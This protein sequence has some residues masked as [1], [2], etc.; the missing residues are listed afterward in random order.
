MEFKNQNGSGFQPASDSGKDDEKMKR[1]FCLLLV[2]C[3]VMLLLPS[4]GG[5]EGEGDATLPKTEADSGDATVYNVYFI[6]KGDLMV[7]VPTRENEMPVP[8][9]GYDDT[10]YTLDKIGTFTGWDKELVAPTAENT[11]NVKQI[12]Y[13]ARYSFETRYYSIVFR[14]GENEYPLSLTAN[15]TP[16]CPVAP[17]T[18]GKEGEVFIGW[19]NEIAAV[20]EDA[21]YTARYMKDDCPT[22][23]TVATW[24]VGHYAM[25]N[26]RDSRITD[27]EYDAKSA[28]YRNYIEGLGA[29]IVCM[30]E[31]SRQF[32]ATHTAQEALFAKTPAVYFAGEQRGFSCNAIFSDLPLHNFEVHEFECNKGATMAKSSSSKPTYYYYITADLHVGGETVVFVFT[33]LSFN[34]DN[35][36][37]Y[38]TDSVAANQIDEL[39]DAFADVEH[40]VMMGDWNAYR[41]VL[42]DP[43]DAAGYTL[44]NYYTTPTCIGSKTGGLEWPVDDIVVKGMELTDFRAVETG[45]SDHIA[46]VATITLPSSGN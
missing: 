18:A 20:K 4:C 45:L 46:V 31:F 16:V 15:E 30:N 41:K 28:E 11:A 22:S 7:R 27:S 19:D 13:T 35:Y 38:D 33:H 5:N 8:P 40:V 25:G 42:F 1:V 26:A 39:I 9:K 29:D 34:D 17:E 21:V 36:D 2:L 43:L 12:V 24:N 37:I 32:T 10:W 23:F 14:V 3:S 6:I 44:G